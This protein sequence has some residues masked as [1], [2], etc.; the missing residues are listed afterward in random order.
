MLIIFIKLGFVAHKE[1]LY[2]GIKQEGNTLKQSKGIF[3]R[4]KH[5][6]RGRS[7]PQ[8]NLRSMEMGPVEYL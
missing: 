1:E 8:R 3:R 2:A 5:K 6:F 7:H 4:R